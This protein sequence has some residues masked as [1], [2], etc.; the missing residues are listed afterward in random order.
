MIP[1]IVP[2]VPYWPLSGYYFLFFA[3]IGIYIPY[4][5]LYLR[6]I[7]FDAEQ[8][9][10]ISAV[11]VVTKIFSTYLWGWVVDRVGMRMPVVQ[12]TA[13]F[14]PLIFALVL[15]VDDFY[16]VALVMFFFS[17][18]WSA[19]L[20]QVEASTLNS[21]GESSYA[22]TFIRLWGSVGFAAISSLGV[23][24][25]FISITYVPWLL[26]LP[27]SLVWL[28]TLAIPEL[29][30]K[31]R[32]RSDPPLSAGKVFFQPKVLALLL[33][34]FLMLASH[35]PYYTFY[36]IY[37][38]ESGYSKT[39]I[40]LMWALGVVAEIVL[41]LFMQRLIMLFG[42]RKLLI[43]SLLMAGLR[44]FLLACFVDNIV[45]LSFAQCLHAGT[46]GIYH[47][48][49]IQYVHS[50]FTGNLQ[51]RGQGLYSSVSFGAGFAVGSILTGYGWDTLGGTACF[52]I[53]SAVAFFAVAVA[54]LLPQDRPSHQV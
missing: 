26:L 23:V 46:F 43:L 30:V 15:L 17:L 32:S 27:M 41:F 34:C 1:R 29:P 19:S 25:E 10:V 8:I 38:E 35:G 37:L 7:R 20:P 4:W 44:W 18:F 42:L 40:G 3:T 6:S 52:G 22:Y 49:A 39:L 53:A 47:A 33:I 28:Q 31:T 51:G 54:W 12:Y 50:Y 24:F 2:G 11:V 16:M 36:S 48:A 13:L 21:L 9:G 45:L 14:S 5:P